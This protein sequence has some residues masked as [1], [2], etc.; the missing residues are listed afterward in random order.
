MTIFV[1]RESYAAM[2]SAF[3]LFVFLLLARISLL[4]YGQTRLGIRPIR[5]RAS[6]SRAYAK[7]MN[8]H[9]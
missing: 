6:F 1:E 5:I 3:L 2:I 4:W 8:A 7:L 9:H